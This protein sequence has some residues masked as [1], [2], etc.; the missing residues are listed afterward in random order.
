V[1]SAWLVESEYTRS[2]EVIGFATLVA[3]VL[4]K[5]HSAS[6][7]TIADSMPEGLRDRWGW[8]RVGVDEISEYQPPGL[9][10]HGLVLA[11]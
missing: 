9:E 7:F 6:L 5:A 11:P 2:E 4:D 1:V 10:N 8:F 3:V